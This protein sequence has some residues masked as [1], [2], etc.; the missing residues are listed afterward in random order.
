MNPFRIGD[1]VRI[2][3]DIKDGYGD[4]WLHKGDERDITGFASDGKGCFFA[5]GM[6]AHYEHLTPVGACKKRIETARLIA[7]SKKAAKDFPTGHGV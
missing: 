6:G 3:I 5:C 4:T 1:I 7:A 2:E